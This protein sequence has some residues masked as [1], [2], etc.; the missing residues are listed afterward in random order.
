MKT[1]ESD[2]TITNVVDRVVDEVVINE[3]PKVEDVQ[4]QVSE[5]TV[6]DG[7]VNPNAVIV[8]VEHV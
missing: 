8:K 2:I 7:V 5:S 3:V 6:V 4:V 1:I